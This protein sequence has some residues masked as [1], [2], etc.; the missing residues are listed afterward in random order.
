MVKN[1][2]HSYYGDLINYAEC[3]GVT[4]FTVVAIVNRFA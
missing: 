3:L 4:A 2:P 1:N